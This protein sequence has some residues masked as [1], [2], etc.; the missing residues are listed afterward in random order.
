M[1]NQGNVEKYFQTRLKSDK[2]RTKTW[3]A[4]I[5][6]YFQG[7][8][9]E[10]DTVLEVGAGW[11]DFINGIKCQRKIAVDIWPGVKENASKEV[12]TYV[13]DAK[14]LDF[15]K[16][17]SVDVIF[18]S[19]FLEHISREDTEQFVKHVKRILNNQGQ[20]ILLQPNYRL[21]PARYF[22]DFTHISIWSD[23]SLAT[24]LV[25]EDFKLR[26]LKPKFLPLSMK[27][28]L[29]VFK[30]LIRLYLYSPIKI[31]AGQMLIISV[32][33]CTQQK[34]ES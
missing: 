28:R 8:I 29:P 21:N 16:D 33:N 30:F 10:S 17:R 6:F 27:S 26:T 20:L 5:E 18:A 9:K 25:S 3:Q 22:D 14:N 1:Q 2:K 7:L 19:N 12:E 31:F 23:T 32:P 34:K 11:C 15:I 4:L 24:Y 13:S